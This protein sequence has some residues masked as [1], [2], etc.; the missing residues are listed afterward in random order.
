MAVIFGQVLVETSIYKVIN[1]SAVR[2]HPQVMRK[3]KK[4]R[5]FEVKR[6]ASVNTL[7]AAT[8]TAIVARVDAK[9]RDHDQIIIDFGITRKGL[10]KYITKLSLIGSLSWVEIPIFSISAL[11]V[12]TRMS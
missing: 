12:C 10:N 11:R 1:F 9:A 2:S 8:I 3:F 4:G 6:G 5:Q 7:S